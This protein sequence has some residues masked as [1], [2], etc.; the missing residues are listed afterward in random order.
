MGERVDIAYMRYGELMKGLNCEKRV[1][2]I[3]LQPSSSSSN[4]LALGHNVVGTISLTS[5]Q[6]C[7]I[8]PTEDMLRRLCLIKANHVA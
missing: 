4:I 5:V 8:N 6:K 2:H 1:R 7:S 3:T